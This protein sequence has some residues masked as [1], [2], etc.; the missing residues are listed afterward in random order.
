M[1][2]PQPNPG[3]RVKRSLTHA[4]SADALARMLL[5]RRRRLSSE[6]YDRCAPPVLREGGTGAPNLRAGRGTVSPY[7]IH[8][9]PESAPSS[10]DVGAEAE[11]L[12]NLLEA[13]ALVLPER[14]EDRSLTLES[15]DVSDQLAE[16][17]ATRG[18]LNIA[19]PRLASA[20]TAVP[21]S[22][23]SR[24]E[25]F[26]LSALTPPP[27]PED[28]AML[29]ELPEAE[30]AEDVPEEDGALEAIDLEIAGMM[31]EPVAIPSPT[32]YHLPPT[33]S[34]SFRAV[35]SF[36]LLAA[37][38]VIPLHALGLIG[39]VRDAGWRAR[40]AGEDAM[41]ALESGA[42]SALSRDPAAASAGFALSGTRFSDAREAIDDLG[43]GVR[44]LSAALPDG[45]A[46]DAAA[47]SDLSR[48]GESLA[49]AGERMADGFVALTRQI[50][51]TPASRLSLLATYFRAALPHLSEA[52]D[53]ISRVP[54]ASVPEGSRDALEALKRRLPV[55]ASG[56]AELLENADL[57]LTAL[58]ADGAKRYVLVFQ[59]DAELRATGGFM[60]SFAEVELA[61]GR[62]VRMHVPGGGTYDVRGMMRRFLS[63][64]GPLTLLSARWEFQ[65][66]NWFP[67]FPTSARQ[68]IQFYEE[69]GGTSVDG[70]VA[71]NASL[72]PDLLEVMGEVEMP[73]YAR[74]VTADNVL[75]EAQKI[76]EIEYDR[77][78]N[79]PKAFIGDLSGALLERA[80]ALPVDAFPALLDRL[81]RSLVERDVQVYFT[82]QELERRVRDL[83]WGGELKRTDGD[84]LMVV[85]TNLGGGKTDRVIDEA[86]DVSVAVDA[87]GT[88]TDTV[89]VTRTHYGEPGALFTGVNNV[90]YLRL[91]VPKGSVLLSASGFDAP[92]P[93][94]FESVEPE[95]EMDDDLL[96]EKEGASR[97]AASGTDISEQGGKTV[98]GNWMQVDPGERATAT[99]TYRLPFRVAAPGA[100]E[101]LA[102]RLWSWL[103]R[104][105]TDR[106]TLTVQ[107]QSGVASR[108]TN[109]TLRIPEALRAVWSSHDLKGATFDNRSDGFFAVLFE[110]SE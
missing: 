96:Y 86:V 10:S 66:A 99:F 70:V 22:G 1:A 79:R 102:D 59:N 47:A 89:T 36:A 106:Y 6:E 45:A 76:V 49:T 37:A 71:V 63:A 13:E 11:I 62:I 17:L 43:A 109:L 16:D 20:F 110:R 19:L 30:E 67:D 5:A 34:F 9:A 69:A 73:G 91:Y 42:A 39:S 75:L 107:K 74:T 52:S 104:A 44:L 24:T 77:E 92:D 50:D 38:F 105:R 33:P 90:D 54:V 80:A 4:V 12:L 51:P 58:G 41:N 29:L 32:T 27:A 60:G 25:G 18:R 83:G 23:L 95:W 7:V 81:A 28:L 55:L 108:T 87:D 48:A 94:L 14:L 82:D 53:L 98:F 57:A 88:V 97:H 84:Y 78:E 93:S 15:L 35:A 85:D 2:V 8:L 68:I 65:D 72:L 103:G 26:D 3:P 64:P 46:P 101:G 31:P 61:E 21:P 56:L 40:A 100:Q